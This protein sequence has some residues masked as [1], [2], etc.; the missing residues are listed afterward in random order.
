MAWY[1]WAEGDTST[2]HQHQR[3][4]QSPKQQ[5]QYHQ[6]HTRHRY[7]ACGSFTDERMHYF[8]N[9]NI[10]TDC[11]HNHCL[12]HNNHFWHPRRPPLKGTLVL[13]P[14]SWD[15]LT[16]CWKELSAL[17]LGLSSRKRLILYFVFRGT[18]FRVCLGDAKAAGLLCVLGIGL[19]IGSLLIYRLFKKYQC[20]NDLPDKSDDECYVRL[21]SVDSVFHKEE[22]GHGYSSHD[23]PA[24][25]YAPDTGVS[26]LL[27]SRKEIS[28]QEAVHI[29]ETPVRHRKLGPITPSKDCCKPE[30][31]TVDSDMKL[32]LTDERWLE[33]ASGGGHQSQDD[34]CSISSCPQSFTSSLVGN[35]SPRSLRERNLVIEN[36]TDQ[37]EKTR[38]TN[39]SPNK[40]N[41]SPKNPHNDKVN[42]SKN[43]KESS[44][45]LTPPSEED[46]P[47]SPYQPLIK[48]TKLLEVDSDKEDD[49]SG[50]TKNYLNY[51]LRESPD[52]DNDNSIFSE[53]SF[54]SKSLSPPSR[55]DWSLDDEEKDLL[56]PLCH[57][58]S[59]DQFPQLL[60]RRLRECK[61]VSPES[62][63]SI[64][65]DDCLSPDGQRDGIVLER[66][67]SIDS[68]IFEIINDVPKQ[69]EKDEVLRF[70]GIEDEIQDLNDEMDD[71][72][73]GLSNL[74]SKCSGINPENPEA[75]DLQR[76]MLLSE[77][78]YTALQKARSHCA[79]R[80]GSLT[81]DSSIGDLQSPIDNFLSWD[82]TDF[83]LDGLSYDNESNVIGILNEQNYVPFSVD[84]DNNFDLSTL[85][86][87]FHSDNQ[88]YSATEGTA[89]DTIIINVGPRKNIQE[90]AKS[91]WCGETPEA[92]RYLDLL[93][94]YLEEPEWE[95]KR[96]SFARRLNFT[97]VKEM[98]FSCIDEF[99][100]QH[101]LA[102][103][104]DKTEREDWVEDLL[105][106]EPIVDI[107]IMEAAKLL[108]LLDIIDVYK[109]QQAVDYP[110]FVQFI[111]A[112]D[113]SHTPADL[114]RNILNA[115]GDNDGLEQ[116]DM[117][118]L[119]HALGVQITVPRLYRYGREDFILKFPDL[120]D[121]NWDKVYLITED[122][123]H[124]NI[125]L[126]D[127]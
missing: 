15:T 63:R 32:L 99:Y 100:S 103:E 34:D 45:L 73:S 29:S 41:P 10:N 106:R 98:L 1:S 27:D 60:L 2:Q 102:L 59:L 76:Q 23:L 113:T 43:L 84:S 85:Q 30:N 19:G 91:Q 125:I 116:I 11:Y 101:N 56:S 90:Y 94:Q 118:L 7:R 124:Y 48:K 62:N 47:S 70:H 37:S 35:Y 71:L 9:I 127:N 88:F 12:H 78:A 121:K 20:S 69:I 17:G 105:N 115:V 89:D 93:N 4:H 50:S 61:S 66:C 42:I 75:T 104:M 38:S 111:F 28:N 14:P 112:R 122:D 79:K 123:R 55:R 107:K 67:D 110:F 117:C 109:N 33:A 65:S 64:T 44:V 51:N 21:E 87:Q 8:E 77:Q 24:A 36:D 74:K 54:S 39:K 57:S 95:L 46:S 6:H 26:F 40:D 80:P 120:P 5:Q 22:M 18:S 49:S 52:D 86:H 114:L 96:W 119:G 126:K 13:F 53:L 25:H 72:M 108:M 82:M 83:Q 92:Q 81:P 97:D 16:Q 31:S 68:S 3:Y 58:A